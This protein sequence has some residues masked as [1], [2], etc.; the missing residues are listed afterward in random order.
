MRKIIST[1]FT[2]FVVMS[3]TMWA[4]QLG[5]QEVIFEDGTEASLLE[6]CYIDLLLRNLDSDDFQALAKKAHDIEDNIEENLLKVLMSLGVLEGDGSFAEHA[7][8]IILAS[9][10]INDEGEAELTD[11]L[12]KKR[13][14]R[15]K[16]KKK[17]WLNHFGDS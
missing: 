2:A 17:K 3:S 4:H 12:P 11:L 9:T 1:L 10:R 15:K 16:I 14:I 7:Q 8:E 5:R 6:K 13:K